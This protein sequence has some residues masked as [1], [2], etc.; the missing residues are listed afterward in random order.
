ME[1]LPESKDT[2]FG[3]IVLSHF[4]LIYTILGM[5][6]EA[7]D[8][9]DHVTSVPAGFTTGYLKKHPYFNRL[10]NNPRFKKILGK[11]KPLL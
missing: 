9:Y 5:E 2:F 10:R 4:G 3:P 6:D 7:I 11:G 8:L 1:I